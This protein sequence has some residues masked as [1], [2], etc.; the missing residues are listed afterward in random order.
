MGS[1][2]GASSGAA[3]PDVDGERTLLRIRERL[4]DFGCLRMGHCF[5][6]RASVG[7]EGVKRER[8][9]ILED[10]QH[11]Q[12]RAAGRGGGRR[13]DRA[14]RRR[15]HVGKWQFYDRNPRNGS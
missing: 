11:L 1:A 9:R 6:R 10:P 3:H 14:R 12:L 15:R 2:A 13:Q 8:S 7:E 5:A 4:P